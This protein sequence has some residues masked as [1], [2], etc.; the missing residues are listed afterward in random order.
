MS[1][2][3]RVWVTSP[4]SGSAAVGGGAAAELIDPGGLDWFLLFV[5][6]SELL[7]GVGG[8]GAGGG[9]VRDAVAARRGGG[10]HQVIADGLAEPGPQPGGQPGPV[11]DGGQPLGESPLLAAWGVAVPAGLAPVQQDLPVAD[12]HVAGRGPGML[13]DPRGRLA[14]PRAAARGLRGG[15]GDH[16]DQGLPV[17][18][19]GH[20]RDQQPGD[21]QQGRRRGAARR[22]ARRGL[23]GPGGAGSVQR[24]RFLLRISVSWSKRES[25]GNRFLSASCCN[26]QANSWICGRARVILLPGTRGNGKRGLKPGG[27]YSGKHSGCLRRKRETGTGKTA[28]LSGAA[29]GTGYGA[30]A[31]KEGGWPRTVTEG[32]QEAGDGQGAVGGRRRAQAGL[33]AR[34]GSVAP[35]LSS[36]TRLL[37]KPNERAQLRGELGTARQ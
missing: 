14:A 2:S 1:H 30:P 34:A 26:S 18:G 4:V 8:E 17:L 37:P 21:P 16:L 23:R 35:R 24:R 3:E 15:V 5:Q 22:A 20:R 27:G 6:V 25:R 13:L 32:N 31:G 29:K 9:A 19:H 33:G 28:P 10:G 7:I 12:E 36:E 11:L